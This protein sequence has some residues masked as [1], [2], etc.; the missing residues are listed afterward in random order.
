MINNIQR[1]WE[2]VKE[3]LY[4]KLMFEISQQYLQNQFNALKSNCTKRKRQE[5][6]ASGILPET[7]ELIF[8][9]GNSREV[10]RKVSKTRKETE[11]EKKPLKM[12]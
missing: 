8:W 1:A 11:E 5:E 12:Y 10:Q 2:Q 6:H 4:I 3:S 9:G 7:S